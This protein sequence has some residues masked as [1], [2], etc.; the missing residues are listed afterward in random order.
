MNYVVYLEVYTVKAGFPGRS[1]HL[2]S[3]QNVIYNLFDETVSKVNS[4]SSD[5]LEMQI[6]KL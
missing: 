6:A 1:G 4:Y 2:Q 5:P 3:F